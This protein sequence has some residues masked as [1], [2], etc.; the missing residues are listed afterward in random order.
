VG[1][2][3][4]RLLACGP[5]SGPCRSRPL[6]RSSRTWP[7]WWRR[8]TGPSPPT[9]ACAGL[10]GRL[11]DSAADTLTAYSAPFFNS[12]YYVS[13]S[14]TVAA[15][16]EGYGVTLSSSQTV[17]WKVAPFGEVSTSPAIVPPGDTVSFAASTT[18]GPHAAPNGWKY[19][20][21]DTTSTPLGTHSVWW[22]GCD[23]YECAYAPSASGRMY[24]GVKMIGRNTYWVPRPI[25]W[26]G[27]APPVELEIAGS[28]GGA[29]TL[30]GDSAEFTV[31]NEGVGGE[32]HGV[33]L[34]WRF[35]PDSVP[36]FVVGSSE[37]FQP[38]TVSHGGDTVWVE[39]IVHP[40]KIVVTGTRD[41]LAAA[42]TFVVSVSERSWEPMPMNFDTVWYYEAVTHGDVDCYWPGRVL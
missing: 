25:V 14:G 29:P 8:P 5:R 26:V 28:G 4:G 1:G 9:R 20:E 39:R 15:C 30:R 18:W 2:G 6:G 34:D 24:W 37:Y 22:V 16:S 42:D 11:F 12:E 31:S 17:E 7:P 33:D 27:N 3:G 10:G 21:G 32:L 41:T 23:D 19:R 38:D 40:G 13:R 36:Y 35:E